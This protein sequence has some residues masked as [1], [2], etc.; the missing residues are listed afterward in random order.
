MQGRKAAVPAAIFAAYNIYTVAEYLAV[1]ESLRSWWN[2]QRMRRIGAATAYLFGLLSV[3][4]KLVGLSESA[5][6]ITKKEVDAPPA[7]AAA[8]EAGRFSFD[9][10]PL[11]LPA[12][13]V[14]LLNSAALP[15]ATW[16]ALWADPGGG[17]PGLGELVCATWAVLSYFPFIRGLFGKGR[18]G[19]PWPTIAKASISASLFVLFS[20]WA[21]S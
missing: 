15:A 2:N 3:A 7:A 11:F 12:A 4:A 9:A 1:G 13:A 14:A 5:F 17:G 19:L 16:R 8:A 18:Y 6:E 20:K 10:S 21:S